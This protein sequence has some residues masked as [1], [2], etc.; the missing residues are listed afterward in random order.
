M[1]N[2]CCFLI[3]LF[4]VAWMR[5]W[6]GGSVSFGLF[7][8][9]TFPVLNLVHISAGSYKL[10]LFFFKNPHENSSE[11]LCRFLLIN[12]VLTNRHIFETISLNIMHFCIHC[13]AFIPRTRA[14]L[15]TLFGCRTASQSSDK[16]ISFN[17]LNCF[18][19]FT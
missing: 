4:F 11:F 12:T 13:Y 16:F 8:F 7:N 17:A 19:Q 2:K 1:Y 6:M 3:P 5:V 15:W 18:F 10:L 14:F 9:L